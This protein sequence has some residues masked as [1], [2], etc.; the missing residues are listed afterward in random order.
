M[1][2]RGR[3]RCRGWWGVGKGRRRLE[4]RVHDGGHGNGGALS[5]LPMVVPAFSAVESV[6]EGDGVREE[7]RGHAEG[8]C[9]EEATWHGPGAAWRGQ[10]RALSHGHGQWPCACME[11]IVSPYSKEIPI[12]FLKE[13]IFATVHAPTLIKRPL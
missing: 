3:K 12:G 7:P 5:P 6:S 10:S 9:G 2:E 8:G 11:A 13:S 1:L 4:R